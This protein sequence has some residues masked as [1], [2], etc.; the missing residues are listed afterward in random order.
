MS[1]DDAKEHEEIP[2]IEQHKEGYKQE[3]K[4]IELYETCAD[5]KFDEAHYDRKKLVESM[6]VICLEIYDEQGVECV[7]HSKHINAKCECAYFVHRSCFQKWVNTRPQHTNMVNCLVCSSEG[8]IVLSYTERIMKVFT[9]R[10][11]LKTIKCLMNVFC[12]FCVF[13]MIW[14]I[15]IFVE[16]RENSVYG[17]E[18]YYDDGYENYMYEDDVYEDDISESNSR[19]QEKKYFI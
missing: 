4:T 15:G 1:H 19:T 6:C 11:W 18:Q 3:V 8:V 10:K 14:Q 2:S 16:N 12:W 17:D 13:M 5:D 7:P 9:N